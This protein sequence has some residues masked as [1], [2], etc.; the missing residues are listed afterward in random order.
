MYNGIDMQ[1]TLPG[2][3]TYPFVPHRTATVRL[4]SAAGEPAAMV[5][6]RV[7]GELGEE[8]QTPAASVILRYMV[9]MCRVAERVDARWRY[10]G[11]AA[12]GFFHV[13]APGKVVRTEWLHDGE[14]L[15][16]VVP[17]A[18]WRG[19]I[20]QRMRIA[21]DRGLPRRHGDATLEQLVKL[22]LQSVFDDVNSP[23]GSLLVDTI[24]E[25]SLMV[26]ADD[27]APEVRTRR[28]QALPAHRMAKAANYV[29]EHLAETITLADMANAAGVSPMHFAAQFRLATG[30]RPHHYLIDERIHRAKELMRDSNCSL[31]AV[32]LATGFNTQAHF[33][34][35]FKRCT[36]MTPKVWRYR[37]QAEA[38]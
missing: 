17:H 6:R 11:E 3:A 25:R 28:L 1:A 35:V 32:A 10:C 15:I 20:T 36:G 31:Q 4:P 7:A 38:A 24:L 27:R 13:S 12:A 30:K 14:E 16:L 18:Y 9:G 8:L 21:M 5:C 26:G 2:A 19:R 33:C 34:T 22:Q 37:C 23:M 29:H